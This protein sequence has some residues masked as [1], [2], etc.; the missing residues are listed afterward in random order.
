MYILVKLELTNRGLTLAIAPIFLKY[1]SCDVSFLT[2]I[3][4]TRINTIKSFIEK[5]CLANYNIMKLL[6]KEKFSNN[7]LSLLSGLIINFKSI[8]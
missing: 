4:V 6:S 1:L 5:R 7:V 2:K 3:A 8:K